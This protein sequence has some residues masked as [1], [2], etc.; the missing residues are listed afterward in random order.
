MKVRLSPPKVLTL[1]TSSDPTLFKSV[2]LDGAPEAESG[3]SLDL[4]ANIRPK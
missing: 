2:R 3:G 4:F 1:H